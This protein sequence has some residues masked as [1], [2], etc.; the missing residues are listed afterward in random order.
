[1]PYGFGLI[2][3]LAQFACAWHVVRTG[4]SYLW[5]LPI[6]VL[7]G[8]GVVAYLLFALL[9]DAMGSAGARRLADDVANT[10]DPGR[11]FREKKRQVAQVGSAQAKR[12]LAEECLKR[13]YFQ[14]AID[15]YQ[16]AM[17]AGFADDPAFL[18]GL[19]RAKLLAGDGAGAETMFE[20]LKAADPAAFKADAELDYARALALQG[21]TDAALAQYEKVLPTFPGEEARARY[22]LLLMQLGQAERAKAVFRE[23]VES[24]RGAPSYYKRRQREWVSIARQNL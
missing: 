4:R 15:L 23:I 13:G 3:L 22:G 7:P 19:G 18:H 16:S 14:D 21:K 9:P 12:D 8:L 20:K 17:D 5:L 2:V 6:I 1:M 11:T 10:V 24:V